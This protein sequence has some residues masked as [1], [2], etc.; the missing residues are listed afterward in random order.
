MKPLLKFLKTWNELLTLPI[1]LLL[2]WISPVLLRMLDPTAA[3]YDS[4]VLQNIIFGVIMFLT[5]SFTA[6]LIIKLQWPKL[7]QYLDEGLEKDFQQTIP[8]PSWQKLYFILSL[9]A[10]YLVCLI[11]CMGSL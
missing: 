5:A 10:L 2:W 3:T 4:G 9:Y 1:A 8:K 7:F 11:I 6:W